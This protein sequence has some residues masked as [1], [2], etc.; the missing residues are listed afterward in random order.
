M[1]S[2]ETG[3]KA[4]AAARVYLSMRGYRIVEQ[5][6]RRPSYEIDIVAEKDG[7]VYFVEVKYRYDDQ[8]GGG[9]DAITKSKLRHMTR[10]AEAW[11]EDNKWHGEYC[12]AAIEI[13]GP[14]FA[15]LSFIDN[16]F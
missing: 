11:V 8:Q 14:T 3:R 2:T 1:N 4:E 10:A 16:V 12:L 13:G 7:R 5:N 9:L 15:V 6:W